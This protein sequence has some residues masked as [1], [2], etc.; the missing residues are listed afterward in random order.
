VT[1][2]EKLFQDL[3]RQNRCGFIEGLERGGA[4]L[5]ELGVPFSDPIA[6]GP[7]I[8]EADD[9]VLA[10]GTTLAKVRQRSEIPLLHFTCLKELDQA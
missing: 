1:R 3:K 5:I 7:V 10:T 9:R 2:I 6:D 4:H 8:Q